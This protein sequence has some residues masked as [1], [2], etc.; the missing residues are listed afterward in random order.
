MGRD[1]LTS[2]GKM[3]WDAISDRP[4]HKFIPNRKPRVA[5]DKT[6]ATKIN[7][8]N[9]MVL[10]I[11]K[12]QRNSEMVV[13]DCQGLIALHTK[14]ENYFCANEAKVAAMIH[15]NLF[16]RLQRILD[17]GTAFDHEI[18]LPEDYNLPDEESPLF[19]R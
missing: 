6:I 17:G 7:E 18:D 2:E 19:V 11:K 12:L 10:E 3:V 9:Q 15:G 13:E 14:N 5:K 16:A 4:N 8:Y 1:E